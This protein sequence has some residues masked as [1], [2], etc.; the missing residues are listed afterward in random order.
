MGDM[1]D[2]FRDMK[3]HR[4][5]TR[6][7]N[8][9]KAD[10][11]FD[12]FVEAATIGGYSLTKMSAYHWNVHRDGVCVAQYWPSSNKWQNTKSGRVTHGDHESFRIRLM[13]GRV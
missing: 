5:M 4:K 10:A 11:E 8:I 9:E 12:Q 6:R 2:A 7:E 13:N 3:N 1:I